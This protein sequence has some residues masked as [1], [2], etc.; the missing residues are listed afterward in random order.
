MAI[1]LSYTYTPKTLDIAKVQKIVYKMLRYNIQSVY[2]CM[3]LFLVG[4]CKFRRC[5][6]VFIEVQFGGTLE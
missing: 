2:V 4:K 6:Y 1:R 5:V 3:G